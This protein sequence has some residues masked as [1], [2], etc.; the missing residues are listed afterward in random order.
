MTKI[1]VFTILELHSRAV[2]SVEA[3]QRSIGP[4]VERNSGGRRIIKKTLTN[5]Y[6][7]MNIGISAQ[8]YDLALFKIL[9]WRSGFGSW[10]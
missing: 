6:Y 2:P 3:H 10:T 8:H 9:F 5:I 4:D 7:T 1:Y